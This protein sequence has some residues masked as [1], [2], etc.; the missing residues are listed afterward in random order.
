MIVGRSTFRRIADRARLC[1]LTLLLLGGSAAGGQVEREMQEKHVV[2]GQ[3]T[4]VRLIAITPFEDDDRQ[5]IWLAGSLDGWKP[6]GRRLVRVASGTYVGE[7]TL[8]VGKTVE[9]KFCRAGTWDSVEKNAAGGEMPNRR[10]DVRGDVGL[11]IEVVH[12]ARWADR[13][14][15]AAV[16]VHFSE[17]AR[18][19]AHPHSLTGD[20]RFH[21]RVSSK[22]FRNE[23]SVLVYL[24]PGY[25]D[26]PTARY[27]VLYMND[28]NNVF[29]AATSFAGVE[30]ELDET[31][32]KLILAGRLRKLIIVAVYNTAG[33]IGEYSPVADARHGGGRAD[34]YLEFLAGTVKPM[35]DRTYR[36]LPGP[37]HTGIAGSSM[38]GL[39]SLYALIHRPD[40]FG[41]GGVMSPSLWWANR[42]VIRLAEKI[43]ANG[44]APRLWLDMG[45]AEGGD[46]AESDGRPTPV[47]DC[48][49]LVRVLKKRGLR[50]GTDF[51]FHVAEGAEHN[52][53]AWARRVDRMLL[54]LFGEPPKTAA[55][56]EERG[57]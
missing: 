7:W 43:A 20:I 22:Q 30:W 47:D 35:I 36:T 37:E 49:E 53:G 9:Y 28:G 6:K 33:R 44:A 39:V 11:Q 2:D 41:S 57:D 27:P 25:D 32:Q 29:D 45:D 24:P 3:S 21:H 18:P 1:A 34:D 26:E 54:F 8:P 51:R 10:L 23:R 42:A 12:I 56:T 40:V 13:D 38:G 4:P 48:R 5:E 46:S 55:T 50:D 52:E 15:P 17:A 14:A 16:S 31:A 19:S